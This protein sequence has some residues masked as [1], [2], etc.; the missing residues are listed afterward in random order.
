MPVGTSIRWERAV[1]LEGRAAT[2]ISQFLTNGFT[3]TPLILDYI[4]FLVLLLLRKHGDCGNYCDCLQSFKIPKERRRT[5]QISVSI[6]V[7]LVEEYP[8]QSFS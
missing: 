6:G 7:L 5:L 1:H 8:A 4:F 2:F 3:F